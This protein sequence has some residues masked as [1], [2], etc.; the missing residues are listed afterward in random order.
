MVKHI[1]TSGCSF[2]DWSGTWATLLNKKVNANVYVCGIS[3]AG[4]S[5]IAKSAI[6]QT[7][8]LLKS[9][10]NTNDIS[11]IVM[12]S[13]I[14]R[15]DLFISANE[16]VEYG[17]L[18]SIL[19]PNP[20]SLIDTIPGSMPKSNYT[21][22]YLLGTYH[23]YFENKNITRIKQELAMYYFSDEAMA[24]ESYENFLRLQWFCE[25]K[26]ITLINMTF[27]DIMYY[28]KIPYPKTKMLTKDY[29]RNIAPLYEML[30]LN[31]WLFW[32]DTGGLFEYVRDNSLELDK[33]ELHPAI[34]SHEHF[35][36]NFLV[37]KLEIN[38][39]CY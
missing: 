34:N 5:W 22:G 9:G 14:D 20:V 39:I 23:S 6:H 26:K 4:N 13:G 15:K 32:K 27:K 2:S 36:D 10:I 31:K 35:L 12:W 16:T 37:P 24:I 38:N 18:V 8:L 30:D 25:S 17:K 29:Y 11:V 1:V 7:N 21:D 3:S 19:G 33:D 28:H